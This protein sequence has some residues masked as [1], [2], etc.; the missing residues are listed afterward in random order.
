MDIFL[1]DGT[2]WKGD[3][4]ITSE[5]EKREEL[6]QSDLIALSWNAPYG[7]VIPVGAYI[8]YTYPDGHIERYSLIEP[9]YPER[10]SEFAWKYR[11]EFVSW[12]QMLSKVPFFMYTH[13]SAGGVTSKE[14]DWSLTDTP[15]NF[16]RAIVKAIELETGEVWAFS[17]ASGLKSSTTLSFSSFDILS[18]LSSIA[19]AFETEY[20]FDKL[21]Q[22][23]HL[24]KAS[25]G[26]AVP[27]EVGVNVGVPS[28]TSTKPFYNRFYV[29]GSTRNIVQEYKGAQV[30]NIVNKRLTLDPVKYPNGYMD[31][32]NGAPVLS[33][34]LTYD[35]IYPAATSLY[36]ASVTRRKM[37]V[38]DS[39]GERVAIGKTSG[40]SPIYDT[41]YIYYLTIRRRT[42]SGTVAFT[43]DASTYDATS[44][45]NGMLLKGLPLSAEFTSGSLNG[46]S[47]EL[48]YHKNSMTLS[49]VDGD[50]YIPA[51]SY[52]I[53]HI[54]EGG[55][56]LPSADTL[57]PKSNDTL[58]LFNCHM[59]SAYVDDGYE[60]L[61]ERALRDINQDY[62]DTTTGLPIDK[63][64]YRFR[65]NPVVFSTASNPNLTLGRNVIFRSGVINLS[66]RVVG[67]VTKL[68]KPSSQEITVGNERIKGTLQ[69]LRDKIADESK[70]L[71]ESRRQA[72]VNQRRA[73]QFTKRSFDDALETMDALVDAK[74]EDFDPPINPIA[75][76]TMQM[77]VGN[78]SLQFYFFEDRSCVTRVDPFTYDPDHSRLSWDACVLK[79]MTLGL[80]NT[81]T[82]KRD[83]SEYLRWNMSSGARVFS[84]EDPSAFFYVYAKVDALND[85]ES[86]LD[87]EFVFSRDPI[88]MDDVDGY[89]HLLVGVVNSEKDGQR[90]FATFNGFTEVLPGQINT[91][92]IQST[93]AETWIN[94][95]DG[96]FSFGNGKL[97]FMNGN[98][99]LNGAFI[100]NGTGSSASL[101][102][103]TNYRGA[104]SPSATYY[105]N[106]MVSYIHDGKTEMFIFTSSTPTSGK[107]PT[108]AAFWRLGT[109]AGSDG[110]DGI[111]GKDGE[112]GKDGKDGVD[113]TD[114]ISI[115]W[116]GSLDETPSKATAKKNQAFYHK[117]LG[118]SLI[119][120]GTDWVVMT[121]DG[122]PIEWKGDLA[123]APEN[124]QKGWAY[125]NTTDKKS[126]VFDGT[127]WTIMAEDGNGIDEVTIK[128]GVSE[129]GV[130]EPEEWLDNVPT[131]IDPGH[132]LWIKTTTTYTDGRTPDVF[133]T[134]S[135]VGKDGEDGKNGDDGAMIV[136]RGDY[137]DSK[138]YTGSPEKREVVFYDNFYYI[139]TKEAGTFTNINP[140]D[141]PEHLYW[142][143]FGAQFESVAT[144]LLVA[145]DG[146]INNLTVN[147]VR[148]SD[149]NDHGNV[150]IA[151][152]EMHMYDNEG[153]EKLFIHSGD[154]SNPEASTETR[155]LM[156]FSDSAAGITFGSEVR[157]LSGESGNL[158]TL[159][160]G[161]LNPISLTVV[162]GNT[163][164]FPSTYVQ[165]DLSSIQVGT[166]ERLVRLSADLCV[167]GVAISHGYTDGFWPADV[168]TWSLLAPLPGRSL[169]L[170][171][172]S[173]SVTIKWSVIVDGA[174]PDRS[175]GYNVH[176]TRGDILIVYTGQKVEIAKNGMRAVFG[177]S[178][179]MAQFIKGPSGT[180]MT[181]VAGDYGIKIDE[182]GISLRM[183][184]LDWKGVSTTTISGK[185]V[186]TIS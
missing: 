121:M 117:L 167:D 12:T 24:S 151:D 79:H 57:V 122:S 63:N 43:F 96:T 70:D 14:T 161:N 136:F 9:Y 77:L 169:A 143:G 94:L 127:S 184:S 87:G 30:N 129:S 156:A 75:I 73:A 181:L 153:A 32:S 44:N 179:H 61:E 53:I 8:V 91:E 67:L 126:Y 86:H 54:D 114:G 130:V 154:L 134:K 2:I 36:V 84:A 157:V 178:N 28:I 4:P 52:E 3:I 7:D 39:N 41:Y 102:P 118:Q 78:E 89:Y 128:Y 139:T 132:W 51:A 183:G 163:V 62:L 101:N 95:T 170:T 33:C 23:I 6:M 88:G 144:K 140:D 173:H 174:T 148:T 150:S 92:R 152:N 162:A 104:Y 5:C 186:L 107:A 13:D 1:I 19:D 111:N 69:E 90:S 34:M 71:E 113:G 60:R 58:V 145:D 27:L 176:S 175:A 22:T 59:P 120:N 72:G 99:V 147:K 38:Y 97:T 65:S 100:Q 160:S 131:T 48:A 115:E 125:Y 21:A 185:T 83:N 64:Q 110:K 35:D 15:D 76:Q 17:T 171:P 20:W 172:G 80:D 74:L 180:E 138:A 42:S 142:Q 40:G 177:D 93:G 158:V 85:G 66:T 166:T 124:P 25:Q 18:A 16:M 108:D 137:E 119:F 45:P 135:Y 105:K 164:T 168:S 123:S 159:S 29:F 103:I 98:L 26:M 146:S 141:D 47:F 49:S 182:S 82:T 149:I 106:D 68:D 10:T 56:I 81:L 155:N 55:Y 31:F 50:V 116:L 11:P 37:Y 46:R 133:Y 112:N 109:S 165:F